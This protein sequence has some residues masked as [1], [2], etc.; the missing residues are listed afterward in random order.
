MAE[1]IHYEDEL[2]RPLTPADAAEAKRHYNV[3]SVDGVV[4]RKELYVGGRIE[5]L[6]Y[7][8]RPGE[9]EA[10][11]IAHILRTYS[12]AYFEIRTRELYGT[13]THKKARM[14]RG[15]GRH[16]DFHTDE[17]FDARGR[18]ICERTE[19]SWNDVIEIETRKYVYDD[20]VE[21]FEFLYDSS[22]AL[23]AIRGAGSPFVPENNHTIEVPELHL[24]FPDLIAAHPYYATDVFLPDSGNAAADY[25]LQKPPAARTSRAN[26]HGSRLRRW[27]MRLLD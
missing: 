2:E 25:R 24:W 27:L 12:L 23:H 11:A 26:R 10:D 7:F 8:L 22:G 4:A 17:L 16:D 14:F 15:D 9:G 1:T 3:Y 5:A 6:V 21:A 19:S 18:L 20:G 13:Y